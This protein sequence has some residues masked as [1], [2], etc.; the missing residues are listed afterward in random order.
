M[1]LLIVDSDCCGLDL[2]YRASVAGHKV[3]WFMPKD[4]KTGK[5][6]RD[7]EGFPKIERLTEWKP[8]MNWAK[9]GL[10]VNLFNDKNIVRELDRFRD[11][12]FP[13][14]G[15]SW[16]ST[17]LEVNRGDGMKA[18]EAV[19]IDVPPYKTFNTLE[20]AMKYA[21]KEDKRLVFKTLGDEE[22]KSMSYVGHNAADMVG[23]IQSW[24]DQGIK[25]KGPC[26]LQDFI[27]GIEVGVSAWMG[28][29]GF[30]PEKFNVN[31]E[32]KKLMAGNFGPSTGE[33]GTMCKYVKKSKLADLVLAPLEDTL[34]KLGHIGDID[35]NC[36]IDENGNPFPLEFTCRFGWPSTQILMES[37]IG[38]PINWMKDAING[39]D[40]LKV[41]EDC[42]MGV[43]MA[44]C[45]FP[46]SDDDEKSVG[47]TISGVEENWDYIAPWQMM[48]EDKQ[49]KTTGTY[50]LMVR[51]TAHE[52]HDLIPKI[53]SIV[54]RIKFPNRIVRDD[55]GKD[56]EKCL[57]LL[58]SYGYDEL[59]DW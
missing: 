46:Y 27:K 54:D 8:H 57:P 31:W 17:M 14:F 22:D 55:I 10:I 35:V 51:S 53:Y 43:L 32:Y 42:A 9:S 23:R 45:P 16:K 58:H 29:D 18:M 3:K 40:S 4:K 37:H 15:P 56:L 59:P 34:K 2:A 52:P 20:E 1:N 47:M 6:P 5:I 7:G 49:Y 21:G 28:K 44:A 11:F 30:L 33:M 50:V 12:G 39:K 36:I 48:I 24:I 26:M 19:G 13:V 25:L 41:T 38:D